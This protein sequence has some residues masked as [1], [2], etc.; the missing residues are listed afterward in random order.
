MPGDGQ[1]SLEFLQYIKKCVLSVNTGVFTCYNAFA[2]I[3]I[4]AYDIVS[5]LDTEINQQ[6][7][8]EEFNEELT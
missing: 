8:L 2:V 1:Q 3:Q 5:S 7:H 4:I 6:I